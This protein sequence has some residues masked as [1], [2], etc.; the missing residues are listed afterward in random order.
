MN[1]GNIM[2]IK[3]LSIL[4]LLALLSWSSP[5][6]AQQRQR[7]QAKPGK[8]RAAVKANAR[9][10]Q[11]VARTAEPQATLAPKVT[12]PAEKA[13]TTLKDALTA[14]NS[15]FFTRDV[16]GAQR[17]I[18]N[19]AG[20]DAINK[21]SVAMGKGSNVIQIVH[22]GQD[23]L[24]H[25]MAIFD[26]ELVHAQHIAGTQNWRLG[27]WGNQLR[28]SNTKMFSA[29]ISLSSAEATV[30][31]NNIKQGRKDQGPDHLAGAD[32]GNGKLK[33]TSMGGCRSFNCTSI[34]SQMP[35]GAKG[36][37]LGDIAGIGNTASGQPRQL[38]KVLETGGNERIIGTGVYGP[39]IQNFGANPA[40]PVVDL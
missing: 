3:F 31:R 8:A 20:P 1:I 10:Q 6:E 25:T 36:E 38:Q 17:F 21:I 40:Q 19:I 11:R 30:L 28:P 23:K 7:V 5:S 29:F 12:K 35:L 24:Q 14:S 22:F 9:G 32:W 15:K 13:K 37:T 16:N 26:G 39:Q 4:S 2:R 27:K 18:A 33:N 34:W